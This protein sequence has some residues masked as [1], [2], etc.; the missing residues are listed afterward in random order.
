M[1]KVFLRMAAI[2][3][4]DSTRGTGKGS[5][6]HQLGGGCAGRS[7]TAVLLLRSLQHDG[8]HLLS[9]DFANAF[10]CVSRA[11]IFESLLAEP[12]LSKL[13]PLTCWLYGSPSSLY[14]R[15]PGQDPYHIRSCTGARQ[16]CVLGT[17]L[18][19]LAV[20][21]L[22][23]RVTASV[24]TVKA[25]A[26]CDDITFAGTAD[27]TIRAFDILRETAP[28]FGLEMVP[29]KCFM[30]PSTDLADAHI[31]ALVGRAIAVNT[32]GRKILGSPFGPTD[33]SIADLATTI[34]RQHNR[35]L[36]ALVSPHMDPK[37]AY[38]ILRMCMAPRLCYLTRTTPTHLLMDALR[39]FDERIQ[40]TFRA[41]VR[42]PRLSELALLQ[43]HLPLRLAGMGVRSAAMVAPIAA[44]AALASIT[45]LLPPSAAIFDLF[46]LRDLLAHIHTE[47]PNTLEILPGEDAFH[48]HFKAQ[49]RACRL[50][51]QI[52]SKAERY[53]VDRLILQTRDRARFNS[54]SGRLASSWLTALP[55]SRDTS[56]SPEG[57][58]MACRF[59]LGAPPVDDVQQLPADQY[60]KWQDQPEVPVVQG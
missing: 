54:A 58:R 31:G 57:F 40:D 4:C 38:L 43:I 42:I 44:T 6:T 13:V 30:T 49:E 51:R 8:N 2:Y 60:P 5:P 53:I 17:A 12:T 14:V 10:N 20:K 55:I 36:D 52:T 39:P 18:F 28:E 11:K 24:P 27:D 45:K 33:Q 3:V 32:N 1:G 25:I 9:C 21:P 23:E 7:Q 41:I 29:E 48:D 16:G 22:Y 19:C 47:F 59:R 50:Q 15:R 35:M 56:M 37:V 46:R 34:V 26:I